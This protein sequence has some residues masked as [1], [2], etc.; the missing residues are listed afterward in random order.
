M[1]AHIVTEGIAGI[2][3][4]VPQVEAIRAAKLA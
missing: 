3:I 4:L 1:V 2:A